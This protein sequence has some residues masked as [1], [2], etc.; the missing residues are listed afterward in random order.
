MA[1]Q[2]E[3]QLDG[4]TQEEHAV[5]GQIAQRAFDVALKTCIDAKICVA[6]MFDELIHALVT[7]AV[8]H[9]FTLSDIVGN[10]IDDYEHLRSLADLLPPGGAPRAH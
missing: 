10:L 5:H 3:D 1:D 4:H 2:D 7:G 8:T 9:E 6:V